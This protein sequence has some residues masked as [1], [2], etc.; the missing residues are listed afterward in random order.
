MAVRRLGQP[1][2]DLLCRR[3]ASRQASI[4]FAQQRAMASSPK[5]QDVNGIPVEVKHVAG[6]L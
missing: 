1:V 6:R 5:Q 2:V 4:G 3:S